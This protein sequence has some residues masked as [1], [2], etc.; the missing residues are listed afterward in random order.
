MEVRA[1]RRWLSLS[2]LLGVGVLLLQPV[3]GFLQT[4][5]MPYRGI[6]ESLY[7]IRLQEALL[8]PLADATNGIWGGVGAPSGM[9]MALMERTAGWIFGWTGLDAT[10]VAV[11]ITAFAA[12]TAILL[13]SALLRRAGSSYRQ[14][15]LLSL[16]FFIVMG[17][18]RRTFNPSWSMPILMAALL[19]LWRWWDTLRVRDALLA[20]FLLGILPGIYFWA[21]TYGW[22]VA[23]I[24]FLCALTEVRGAE[25]RRR[26]VRFTGLLLMTVFVASP[27]LF[28]IWQTSQDP[29]FP[30]A[31]LR[32]GL[33]YARGFE[34]IPRSILLTF[35]A[36]GTFLGLRR[37]KPMM[38]HLPLLAIVLA[39]FAVMHQQ[40]IHGR[41]MSFSSHYYW[42]VC[43][44]AMLASGALLA[45][46]RWGVGHIAVF[47]STLLLLLGAWNDYHGRLTLFA[48]PSEGALRFSPLLPLIEEL[49]GGAVETI[50]TDRETANVIA[51]TTNDDVVYTDYSKILL[52][53]TMER[54]QR[55]C[56]S[57]ALGTE[58]IDETF[59]AEFDD[60][61]SLAGRA[62]AEW[63]YDRHVR[64]T[65]E[66][67]AWVRADLPRALRTFGVTMVLW[68]MREQPDWDTNRPFLRLQQEEEEEGW[69]VF[70]VKF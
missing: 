53:S 34:S 2:Y 59:L 54:A 56:L 4:G 58:P 46:P 15:L 32:M 7:A 60:E 43:L 41:I 66:A 42:Y 22:A 50:L 3:R 64:M 31:S 12:P 16:A 35:L 11:L 38:S 27:L 25:G 67:C 68:N 55:Y 57:E 18:L 49:R 47:G 13:M 61:K 30:E 8:S 21:W 28:Q 26:V 40:F 48:A 52:I 14:A 45:R 20:A 63:L 37:E 10:V 29:I 17:L 51:S 70:E 23:G 65:E 44:A 62:Q 5:M 9:Q 33:L 69:K 36:I 39:A 24:L 1:Y 6:D 19:A